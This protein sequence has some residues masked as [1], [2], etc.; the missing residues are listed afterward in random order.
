MGKHPWNIWKSCTT[1]PKQ[2]LGGTASSD[3]CVM[4]SMPFTQFLCLWC[5]SFFLSL[6]YTCFIFSFRMLIKV[7][8]HMCP[9]WSLV[10]D[11]SKQ[12]MFSYDFTLNK[13]DS[14]PS[15]E[16]LCYFKYSSTFP[17]TFCRPVSYK[18][19]HIQAMYPPSEQVEDHSQINFS[20]LLF[21]RK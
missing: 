16:M 2:G 9:M 1:I 6:E 13:R 8:S 21:Q 12:V 5:I 20:V 7:I 14:F 11:S 10:N 17:K 18:Y 4:I 19:W 3:I 15:L